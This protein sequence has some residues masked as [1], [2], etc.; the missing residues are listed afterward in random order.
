MIGLKYKVLKE[1]NA[2]TCK[3]VCSWQKKKYNF[4][5]GIYMKNNK[6]DIVG[7]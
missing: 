3:I 5:L 4:L 1:S 2:I 7:L 6:M